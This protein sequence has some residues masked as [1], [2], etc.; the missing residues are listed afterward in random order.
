[1]T[2]HALS[3]SDASATSDL[4]LTRQIAAG[5]M[6]AMEMLY[7][8]H[9]KKVYNLCF[10]MLKNTFDAEDLA[11]DVFVTLHRKIGTFRGS[12]KFS[13]WLHR[14]TVNQVRMHWRRCMNKKEL[15]TEEGVF[16]EPK[17]RGSLHFNRA[18]VADKID[19]ERALNCLPHGYKQVYV[20][21]EI[22][23]YVHDE[24]AR[25]LN[26]TEGT[27]KSQLHKA[28]NKMRANFQNKV[29]PVLLPYAVT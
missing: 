27:T 3:N 20:M 29:K 9:Y 7:N 8:K 23:G 17:C 2:N 4:T 19:L 22:E 10:K 28:R 5:D 24:I 1:M 14:L 15:V 12:S 6:A 13:T 16:P 26:C 11:Q 25:M 18:P 21:Y